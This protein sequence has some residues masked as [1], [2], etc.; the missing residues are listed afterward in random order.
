MLNWKKLGNVFNPLEVE[1]QPW[2]EEYAQLP[3]PYVLDDNTV[4][5]YFATRPKRGADLQYVSRSGFV[6]LDRFDLT[7]VKRIGEN[8]LFDLGGPGTFDEFGSMT[9]CFVP[10]GDKIYGYYTGWSR[11]YTVPYTMAVGL[12]ISE[13]GGT[14]FKKISEGPILGQTH[15]EPYLLSGPKIVRVEDTWHMWYLIG[16][17][18][19]Q[20]EGKYE[21]VYKFAHATSKDG[22]NWD[23]DGIPV[24]P[25][26]YEDEC[27]V[28]FSIFRYK[29]K[30]NA[31]FAYR[32]PL[33]FRGGADGAYRLGY[34]WSDDLEEW[35]REDDKMKIDVSDEG[36]DSEMMAYPQVSEI[37]GK[38]YIFYCGNE[39]GRN[40][41]G[42]AELIEE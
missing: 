15:K 32:Q 3:F 37:D 23:R 30:W 26:K 9:S 35:H 11:L 2:M 17:K 12:A 38:I 8:P 27:Q 34:A 41:F 10:V 39:F 36:W 5:V 18:W 16:T 13:D 6:D 29:D 20:H 31:V 1:T 14:T 42:I 7:K 22:I 25:S 19:L 24:I 40:G 4:R 21:P 33:D 28:S